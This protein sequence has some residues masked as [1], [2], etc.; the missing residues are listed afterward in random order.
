MIVS[1]NLS[2]NSSKHFTLTSENEFLVE[3]FSKNSK[4]RLI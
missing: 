2:T 1:A 4:K 3:I